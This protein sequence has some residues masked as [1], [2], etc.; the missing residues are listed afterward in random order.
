MGPEWIVYRVWFPSPVEN[1]PTRKV[2]LEV[3]AHPLRN[4]S[5]VK[6]QVWI[7]LIQWGHDV[8]PREGGIDSIGAEI[9]T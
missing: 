6:H 7:M 2:S 8:D 4:P 1:E 3:S 9:I 5:A